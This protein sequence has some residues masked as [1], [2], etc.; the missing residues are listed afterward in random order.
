MCEALQDKGYVFADSSLGPV[1]FNTVEVSDPVAVDQLE[2]MLD[3]ME[4][5]ED[6]QEVFHNWSN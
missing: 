1:A 6:I 5:N 4:E 2:K 3:M